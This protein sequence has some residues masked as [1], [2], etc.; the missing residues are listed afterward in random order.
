[1]RRLAA[2]FG[3]TATCWGAQAAS[4]SFSAAC[5]KALRRFAPVRSV[6]TLEM[7]SASCRRRQA[8]SLRSPDDCNRAPTCERKR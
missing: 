7:S 2:G 4:L 5:R 3:A 1:M 8:G 6:A